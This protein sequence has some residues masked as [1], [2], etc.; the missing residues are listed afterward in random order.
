M[1]WDLDLIEM[2]N[3]HEIAEYIC[4][5]QGHAFIQD[6]YAW[7]KQNLT[8]FGIEEHGTCYLNVNTEN[9]DMIMSYLMSIRET[10]WEADYLLESIEKNNKDLLIYINW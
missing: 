5:C 3:S 8:Y 1:G 2:K 6:F 9:R 4:D 10:Y 7:I